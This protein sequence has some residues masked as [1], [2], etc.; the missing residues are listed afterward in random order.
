MDKQAKKPTIKLNVIKEDIGYTAVGQWKDRHLI[1]SGDTWDELKEMVVEMLNL[2]F[3]DLGFTYAI[4]EVQFE[5]DLESFFDFYKIIN[6][7]ALSERIGMSQSLLAQYAN[8]SKKPSGKQLQRIVRGVQQL[9]REL[10]EV[11]LLV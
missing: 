3:E 11:S 9:G 1:T 6:A 5:Y 2:M 8:G 7:K 10:S 4:D